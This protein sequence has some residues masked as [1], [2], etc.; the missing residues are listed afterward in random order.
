MPTEKFPCSDWSWNPLDDTWNQDKKATKLNARAQV[1]LTFKIWKGLTLDS[2]VQYE[3]IDIHNDSYLNEN[4]YT[5]RQ[6]LNTTSSWDKN[7]DLV[8]VNLPKGGMLTR[9]RS[10]YSVLTVR[11]QVNFNHTFADKHSVAVVG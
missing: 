9:N 3:L 10:K 4:S 11:N 5:V 2:K 6:I 8:T 1:G 7:T